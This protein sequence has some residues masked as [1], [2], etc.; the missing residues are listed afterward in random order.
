MLLCANT[1]AI[2][3]SFNVSAH[4]WIASSAKHMAHFI[5]LSVGTETRKIVLL[6]WYEPHAMIQSNSGK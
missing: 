3:F 2:V 4:E 6:T 1:S 5:F